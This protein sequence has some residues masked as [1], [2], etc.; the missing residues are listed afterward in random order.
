MEGK[1]GESGIGSD[2][3]FFQKCNLRSGFRGR[4]ESLF[5]EKRTKELR[6]ESVPKTASRSSEHG[7]SCLRA[8]KCTRYTERGSSPSSAFELMSSRSTRPPNATGFRPAN[9]PSPCP[10]SMMPAAAST[11]SLAWAG[12]R[13]LS[14]A[15]SPPT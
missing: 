4:I 15:P 7:R 3:S 6:V 8:I 12:L 13:P 11:A 9:T 5:Q 2:L 1:R 14:T 10:S